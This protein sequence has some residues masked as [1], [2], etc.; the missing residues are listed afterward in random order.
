MGWKLTRRTT[1]SATLA[2]VVAIVSAALPPTGASAGTRTEAAAAASS[3]T[4]AAKGSGSQKP[5]PPRLPRNFR[6]KGKW[7]VRDLGITVPFSWQGKNGDSQMTAGGPQYPIWFTNL[8]Y[9]DTLYTLTYK[10]PG[11]NVHS[12]SRIPGVGLGQ[13]NQFLKGSRFVGR[14]TLEGNPR[15]HVNHW[16][17]GVVLP[18]RPPGLHLRFPF[19]L[20]DIYVDQRNRGTFWQVLQFG[21]QNLYDPE[22]DEWLKMDT[23]EHKPGKVVLPRRCAQP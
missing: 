23:F 19:A 11:L 5:A 14:E 20:G 8:I 16:R 21:I 7:I 12:C 2:G 17:V 3:G 9:H 18:K 13:L 10:W 6:G 15:R 1:A 22:L 4:V